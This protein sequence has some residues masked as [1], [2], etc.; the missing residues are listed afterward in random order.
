VNYADFIASKQRRAP[1]TGMEPLPFTAPL[2]PFQGNLTAWALQQGR[3]AIF[4]D[5]GLGKTAMQLEW[6]HQ[7]RQHTGRPVLGIAPLGVVAQTA[8]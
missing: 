7:V 8:E 5:T 4:A 1:A 3:A 6:A 2:F